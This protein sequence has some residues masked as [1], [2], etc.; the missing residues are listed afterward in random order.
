M[1]AMTK[2]STIEGMGAVQNGNTLSFRVWAPFASDVAVAGTFNN[3]SDCL[4][5]LA[6][7]GN[8][9]W[10]CE[11][12]DA[13]VGDKYQFVIINKDTGREYWKND[14]YAREVTHSV[15]DSVIVGDDFDW[16][17]DDFQ[18]A[19]WN[20]LVIYEM[21]IGTFNDTPGGTPGNLDL[22]IEKLD[23]LQDLSVNA[24]KIMPLCEFAA[25]FSWG[26]NPA[27]LFAVESIYG[28][29]S[30]LKRFI[31]EAHKRKIA[32][33]IDVVYNH[34]GPSDL[35]LWRFDGW[36]EH[37]KGGIY[38]Y[39]DWR[40]KTPWGDTRPDYGRP[41]VRQF[42]RD[43]ALMWLEEFRAD[44]LRWDSTVNIRTKENGGGGDIAEGW[45]L[46]SWINDEV[47]H[48]FPG[49][50][51]I[52]EDLQNNQW[53][54][55]DTSIGGA[56]FDSQWAADFVHPIRKA[57]IEGNDVYRNMYAVKDAICS[58]YNGDTLERIIYTES[59]DEVANGHQRVPEEIC[60][61]NADSWFSRKRAT[62]GAALV[63]TSPGI[64]MLFQGQEFLEDQW[65]HDTDP[66]DFSKL[67]EHR[68]IHALFRDLI[69]L[70]RN[71]HNTTRGLL[72]RHVHVSHI[73]NNDKVIAFHRWEQGGPGDDVVVVINMS[74][75]SFNSYTLGF[76]REGAWQ[77]RFNSDWQGYGADFGNHP[78]YHTYA[79]QGDKDGVG[80]HAN[81]GIAPYSALI[82]S[83][84]R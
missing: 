42:I 67:N 78:G 15:G 14:P 72:G 20:E 40:S 27:H 64:P 4:H 19:N 45:S 82:L 17:D 60:P 55:K 31:R 39:N 77:V 33:I 2:P 69:R 32:V 71:W 61:G 23:Y 8:G 84:E 21:H 7:E 70:R 83:Q 79:F 57:I 29:P 36:Q 3:W 80:Y 24:L 22:A 34:F 6:H 62:L 9:F 5:P 38:F 12:N 76:P 59:H 35:D 16:Q 44:G 11:T 37:G 53:L 56:G 54:T 74:N 47:N 43:N 49:K 10:S 13:A 68:G 26:Y 52:A 73:N 30:G 75:R 58:C 63:F 65:F 46:M 25:D 1:L 28:G 81:V 51:S 50:I 41:E 66:I 18:I 48:L